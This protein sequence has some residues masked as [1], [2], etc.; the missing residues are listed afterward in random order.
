MD[1]T[2]YCLT[3]SR[4]AWRPTFEQ[5]RKFKGNFG[6]MR[7]DRLSDVGKPPYDKV[8]WTPAYGCYNSEQRKYIREVYRARSYTHFVLNIRPGDTYH[9]YFPYLDAT[10][11]NVL[12]W[13]DELYS[14]NLIPVPPLYHDDDSSLQ[15]SDRILKEIANEAEE[16]VI[17]KQLMEINVND[18]EQENANDNEREDANDNEQQ[19]TSDN[20]QENASDDK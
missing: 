10:E 15:L 5:I 18:N 3:S 13:L 8:L 16:K 19:D 11:K 7:M 12:T 4:P 9:N 2:F 17:H 6:C 1:S 14:D 20:E